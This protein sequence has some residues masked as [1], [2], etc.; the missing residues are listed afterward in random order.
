[1]PFLLTSLPAAMADALKCCPLPSDRNR[2]F[3]RPTRTLFHVCLCPFPPL[4]SPSCWLVF[5]SFCPPSLLSSFLYPTNICEMPR[6]CARGEGAVREVLW[7]QIHQLEFSKSR[8]SPSKKF[9][10][11]ACFSFGW[12]SEAEFKSSRFPNFKTQ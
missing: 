9:K 5:P 10:H 11:T 6:V 12:F 2:G 3:N 8:W 7:E 1:M 4:P